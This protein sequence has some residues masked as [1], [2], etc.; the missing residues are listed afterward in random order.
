MPVLPL[1][2]CIIFQFVRKP[3]LLPLTLDAELT[4]HIEGVFGAAV[5]A[6]IEGVYSAQISYL[7]NSD[8]TMDFTKAK[9]NMKNMGSVLHNDSFRIRFSLPKESSPVF[10]AIY[11]NSTFSDTTAFVNYHILPEFIQCNSKKLS[12]DS[13]TD[14]MDSCVKVS[15][16]VEG[17]GD[18]YLLGLSRLYAPLASTI[19]DEGVFL[20]QYLISFHVTNSHKNKT[21]ETIYCRFKEEERHSLFVT[22]VNGKCMHD[23]VRTDF[24]VPRNCPSLR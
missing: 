17:E 18:V 20:G 8:E 12:F 21:V 2:L 23:P 13:F 3:I 4:I 24:S 16:N 10:L 5:V 9:K 11:A 15:V 19:V 1:V 7:E 22:L 14:L 6:H